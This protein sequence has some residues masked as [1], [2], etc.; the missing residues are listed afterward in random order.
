VDVEYERQA[1]MLFKGSYFE[2][3]L[4]NLNAGTYEFTVRETGENLSKSG[5]FRIIEFKPEDQRY[6]SNYKKMLNLS[7]NSGGKLYFPNEIDNLV[8]DLLSSKD[9]LPI[10]KSKQNIIS[11]IDF[12]ILLGLIIFCLAMEWFLRKY[13][14]LI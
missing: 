9:D 10:Q 4:D 8:S 3:D 6:S 7:T 12:R 11:L 1:P 14:G 13:N 2:Y 5:T